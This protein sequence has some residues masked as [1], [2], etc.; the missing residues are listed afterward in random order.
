MTAINK[1]A[2]EASHLELLAALKMAQFGFGRGRC[3]VCAGWNTTIK[4]SEVDGQH[5]KTC[6][7]GMAICNA[8]E[9]Y[10]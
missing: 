9:F 8:E 3:A 7:V 2:L 1:Q 10:D 6:P 5:T 4:N